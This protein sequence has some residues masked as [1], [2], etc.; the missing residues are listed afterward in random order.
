MDSQMDNQAAPVILDVREP[1][2]SEFASIGGTL[3]PL[4]QLPH[5]L[6]ELDDVKDQDIVVYCRSGARSAQAVRFLLAQG[7]SGAVNLKGGIQAWSREI[8]SSIPL[9]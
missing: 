9:Y 1:G 6:Q 5:R 8:D 7:F 4:G 3:I 2:E